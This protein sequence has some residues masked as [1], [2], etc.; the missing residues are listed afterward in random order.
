[1]SDDSF[2]RKINLRLELRLWHA[3]NRLLPFG[4][5][6]LE[7]EWSKMIT[8]LLLTATPIIFHYIIH[9][10]YY[11]EMIKCILHLRIIYTF[12]LQINN[13]LLS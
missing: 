7:N 11:S 5:D 13:Y 3:F 12:P 4:H 9:R 10:M 8:L 6:T 1:M 2:G